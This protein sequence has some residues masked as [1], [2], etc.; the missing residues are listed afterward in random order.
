MHSAL[1]AL[2]CGEGRAPFSIQTRKRIFPSGGHPGQSC[3]G[4]RTA[5]S[6]REVHVVPG[7]DSHPPCRSVSSGSSLLFV[8]RFPSRLSGGG[9]TYSQH[10]RTPRTPLFFWKSKSKRRLLPEYIY[11]AAALLVGARALPSPAVRCSCSLTAQNPAPLRGR[12]VVVGRVGCVSWIASKIVFCFTR[13]EWLMIL[14]FALI[15]V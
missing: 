14:A 15:A 12:C 11:L 2:Q 10:C 7:P 1:R 8:S 5:G 9:D 3:V 4:M 6:A 13:P